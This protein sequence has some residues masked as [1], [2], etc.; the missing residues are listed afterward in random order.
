MTRSDAPD[1]VTGA[2]S[3]KR[4]QPAIRMWSSLHVWPQV[5]L[6]GFLADV[7]APLVQGLRESGEIEQYFFIRY[8]EGGPHIRLRLLPAHGVDAE[9]LARRAENEV[10]RS[11]AVLTTAPGPSPPSA[12]SDELMIRHIPYDPEVE[13]Y[14]GEHALPL[15]E[16]HFQDSSDA[17]LRV[18]GTGA[19]S[20]SQQIGMGVQLHV[21]FARAFGI[22]LS[23]T[24]RLFGLLAEAMLPRIYGE[25]RSSRSTATGSMEKERVIRSEFDRCFEEAHSR[26]VPQLVGVWRQASEPGADTPAWLRAWVESTRRFSHALRALDV[27]REITYPDWWR[28]LNPEL[29]NDD[30]EQRLLY[31]HSSYIHMTNNR[32]GISLYDEAYV[33]YLIHRSLAAA[34]KEDLLPSLSPRSRGAQ[35]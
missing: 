16:G 22:P 8:S 10:R 15:A 9:A 19:R 34:M 35:P 28:S 26:I 29:D 14:G 30:P 18:L 25:T 21:A 4:E 6:D 23:G 1:S 2:P 13:R 12:G 32:L 11:R 17:I 24:V 20:Y 27:R 31:L 33:A 3:A 5:P 7:I